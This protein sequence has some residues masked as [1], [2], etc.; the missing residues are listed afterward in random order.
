MINLEVL[1]AV[2]AEE[3]QSDRGGFKKPVQEQVTRKLYVNDSNTLFEQRQL[4]IKA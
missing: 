4:K 2:P 1:C 3:K